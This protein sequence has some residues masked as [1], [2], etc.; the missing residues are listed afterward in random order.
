M[1]A[2]AGDSPNPQHYPRQQPVVS[3][4]GW[5]LHPGFA[6]ENLALRLEGK[7]RK[8]EVNATGYGSKP[9]SLERPCYRLAQDVPP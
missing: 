4:A 3:N 1:P 6:G 5:A 2:R 9:A 8:G 7:P